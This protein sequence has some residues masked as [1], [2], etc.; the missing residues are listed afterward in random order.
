[1]A[2]TSPRLRQAEQLY[3]AG[4]LREA[5]A[6][7]ADILRQEPDNAD[8]LRLV[9]WILLGSGHAAKAVE[10]LMQVRAARSGNADDLFALAAAQR[11][12]GDLAGAQANLEQAIAIAPRFAG[13]HNDLGATHFLRGDYA[14]AAASYR[15]ALAVQPRDPVALRNL[16]DALGATGELREALALY[17]QAL[18]LAP[19]YADALV[20]RGLAL[21]RLG[22]YA[23]A[24]AA[25]RSA[26][27]LQPRNTLAH[28]NLGTTLLEQDRYAEA[29]ACFTQAI[30]L[31]HNYAEAWDNLGTAHRLRGARTDALRCHREALRLNPGLTAALANVVSESQYLCEWDELP[32]LQQR[33]HDEVRQ[34]HGVISPFAALATPGVAREQLAISRRWATHVAAPLQVLR[35]QLDFRFPRGP[36]ERLR[37]GYVTAD[38]HDHPT[39]YLL[40]ELFERH[41]RDRV[42]VAV[43]S[44]GPDASSP[45]RE[46]L[47][48]AFDLFH[49]CRSQTLDHIA[50]QIHED[51]IDIAIELK[52]YTHQSR[53]GILALR[54]APIQAQYMGFPGTLGADWID[55][56][57]ADRIVAPPAAAGEFSEKIVHLPDC[58]YVAGAPTGE[59]PRPTRQ[60]C[61][62][63]EEAFVF[64]C[65]NQL[66]KIQPGFF[67]AWMELLEAVPKSVL[68]LL[69]DHPAAAA[70]LRSRARARGIGGERIVFAPKVP[71]AEHLARLA[72]ADV[73]LDTLPYNAHTTSSDALRMGV[74]VITMK[75]DTFAG[76]VATSMLNTVGLDELVTSSLEEYRALAL[77]FARDDAFRGS[78]R[79][80]LA[81]SI[82]GSPLFDVDRFAHHM[83]SAFRAMWERYEQGLTPDHIEVPAGRRS[84]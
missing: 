9:G 49:D 2:P 76:R 57:I 50:R 3:H 71:Q 36:R 47:R 8:A 22:D 39:A 28:N 74:P 72:Q 54:P 79:E 14:A 6:V 46:R 45:I 26:I 77:R 30:A 10:C 83:E 67:D 82:P 32:A 53:P 58:Y 40:A 69:A 37:I 17:D 25:L 56:V 51:G 41:H 59:V 64:C 15:R 80:R 52:G 23:P 81:A 48:A 61:S 19:G 35:R 60:Q 68:W 4:Q 38:C 42:W 55:Y 75:G 7:C 11:A 12:T 73:I 65:F 33:L 29:V 20:Q 78:I 13:A 62:L 27:A 66:Y 44:Y 63:P 34:A 21:Y 31:D 18:A 24:E 1:M 84:L 43:Y 5:G 16:G 70:S